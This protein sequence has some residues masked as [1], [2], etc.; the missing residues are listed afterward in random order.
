MS[1]PISRRML[2][3]PWMAALLALGLLALS[4]QTVH[5]L[6][7][8]SGAARPAVAP[9]SLTAQSASPPP[10]PGLS[11][12]R[13]TAPAT[14]PAPTGSDVF[15][16][17]DSLLLP[18]TV[19][20]QL[21]QLQN[22][23]EVTVLSMLLGAVGVPVDKMVL[24]REQPTDAGQPTFSRPGG[25]FSSITAWGNPNRA[26]VGRV[27]VSYGY[28]IYHGPLATLLERI[29]PGRAVDLSGQA[30]SQVLAQLRRRVPV[31]LWTT[32]TMR[33]PT[34]WATWQ[35]PDGPVRATQ[36]EHAVLLVGY[37][38]RGLVVDDPL[39]GTQRLVAAGPFIE[40]WQ[41]LG[42]QA[43]SVRPAQN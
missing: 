13:P 2:R 29:L 22:G 43:L 17:T 34:S 15:A 14:P 23:C 38:P 1:E 27:A 35:T 16:E 6:T 30:F 5:A 31:M 20:A 8:R 7:G 28:G 36:Q 21:P 40:A 3:R 4:W 19:Q 41:A 12:P 32:T 11:T 42:R 37:T 10:T 39:T 24:A 25:G 18:A 33:P 9:P 26:F